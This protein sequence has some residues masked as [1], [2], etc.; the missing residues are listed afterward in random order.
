MFFPRGIERICKLKFLKMSRSGHRRA[1]EDVE[2][3]SLIDML[4]F[5]LELTC[6]FLFSCVHVGFPPPSPLFGLSSILC[7]SKSC[8][9]MAEHVGEVLVSNACPTKPHNLFTSS[10]CHSCHGVI[11]VSRCWRRAR[12]CQAAKAHVLLVGPS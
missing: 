5:W 7:Y 6:D 11:M 12:Q 2:M 9:H 4:H 1:F 8:A 3:C 10:P